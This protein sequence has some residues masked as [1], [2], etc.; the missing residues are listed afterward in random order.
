MFYKRLEKALK[1]DF[2]DTESAINW[3]KKEVS[4]NY[5]DSKAHDFQCIV[6]YL[7]YRI[8][9]NVNV[10]FNEYQE[11]EFKRIWS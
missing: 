4:K 9:N 7:I 3:C 1:Q 8:E 2:K 11:I 6:E 5:S 10:S